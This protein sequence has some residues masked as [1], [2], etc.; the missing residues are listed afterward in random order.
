MDHLYIRAL[1]VAHFN[2]YRS[3]PLPGKVLLSYRMGTRLRTAFPGCGDFAQFLEVDIE[4]AA[5]ELVWLN[6]L[7]IFI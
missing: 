1:L 5:S 6:G 2:I 4:N 3:D 7:E